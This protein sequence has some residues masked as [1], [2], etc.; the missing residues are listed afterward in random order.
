[1]STGTLTQE[2][3]APAT[4]RPVKINDVVIEVA[5]SNGTGSQS[6][7][8]VLLR[9]IFGMGVPVGGKNMFPSNI[10]GLPTWFTI[11]ANKDGWTARREHPDFLVAMN[12]ESVAD[13][14]KKLRAGDVLILNDELKSFLNRNDLITYIVPFNKIVEPVC[15]EAK[16]RRMVVNMVYVGVVAWLLDIELA[17][18]EKA[19]SKQFSSKPKAADL[20]KSAARAGYQWASENANRNHG[21]KIE[22]MNKTAGK[23]LIE[24]NAAAAMG[25]LFGGVQAVFWYPITP[26]SSLPE[27][28]ESYLAKYRRDENGKATYAVIQAEDEIASI[29]MVAGA[30]WAGARAMTSTSGPGISLMAEIAG[31]C[32]FAEVP[33]VICDVQRVGPSTGLPTRTSQGDITKAYYLSHGDCKHILLLPGNMEELYEFAALSLDTAERFQTLVFLITDLDFGMN[34]WMSDPFKPLTKPLDRGKVLTAE[35][36]TKLGKFQRYADVDGDG[37]PY[38]TLP[39]TKHPLAAYFTRGTGHTINATYSEK[40]EDWQYGLDRLAKKFETARKQLPAPVISNKG[41]D[42][43]IIAFGSS[44]PA[45]EEARFLLESES[46]IKTDYLRMRALPAHAQ[47]QEFIEK[48]RVTYL[49]EQNRDAQMAS[50]LRAEWPELANKIKSV[51][52]YN[53]LPLDARSVTTAISTGEKKK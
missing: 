49:V 41:S 32:Y 21:F 18:V 10:Q 42:I 52:H 16:L 27:A 31:L 3:T 22:R 43:G 46:S 34:Y 45:V 44:D 40:S 30:G 2:T 7:N 14:I 51:L 29:A 53:G 5:T 1:M 20:N 48:H 24:G 25:Y 39:G 38:R 33:A 35:Q 23:I 50:I 47:V 8:S 11:R 37:I 26:S 19:I 36:L 6:A 12:V 15:P 13:D 4:A 9:S 17:E 28:L